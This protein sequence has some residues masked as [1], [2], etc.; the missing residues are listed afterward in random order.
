FFH[1][2]YLAVRQEGGWPLLVLLLAL[3][4]IAFMA[5]SSRS[6]A[7]DVPAVAAQAALIAT[8]AMGVT[9][10]E[11]LLELPTALAIGFA[12]ARASARTSLDEPSV[13]VNIVKTP[14]SDPD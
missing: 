13:V 9:L 7:G 8:L 10:G 5:L 12:L 6:R 11:V 3:M 2:S 4:A 1:N 14:R